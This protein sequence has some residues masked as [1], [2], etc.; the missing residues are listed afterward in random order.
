MRLPGI[1]SGASLQP[2]ERR[3]AI[4]ASHQ[5]WERCLAAVARSSI[6]P[7]L[8]VL[9]AYGIWILLNLP[10]SSHGVAFADVGDTFL[11]QGSASARIDAIPSIGQSIG[12]D[13]QFVYY[14]ALDATGARGYIDSPAYR[15]GR[16]VLSILAKAISLDQAAVIPYALIVLNWLAVGLGT[17]FVALWL[18]RNRVSQWLALVYGLYPGL[19]VAVKF[20][21]TEALAYC[22]VAAAVLVLDSGHRERIVWSALLFAWAVLSRETTALFALPFGFALLAEDL[23]SVWRGDMGWS[24]SAA[25]TALFLGITFG[26]YAAWKLCL[27]L[28]LG[29]F[30]FPA[31][32]RPTMMPFGGLLAWHPWDQ[33]EM[34][35]VR[36][37]AVPAMLCLAVAVF[38]VL[39]RGVTSVQVWILILN[40]VVLVVCL[41]AASYAWCAD[42]AR[43]AT[44]VPLAAIYALP[45]IDTATGRNRVWIYGS[46]MLWLWLFIPWLTVPIGQYLP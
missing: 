46:A 39:E 28:W 27:R 43:I 13:G 30:G 17:W 29:D 15:Y 21:L 22:F 44:G 32:L 14:I 1:N 24:K 20:D 12:Y 6:A 16:I 40:V 4:G 36:S 35:E 5:P 37:I 31:S 19:F 2:W 23:R 9:A 26:P 3:S 34:N 41:N 7:A 25:R 38:C 8:L 18:R 33:S 45:S 10:S 42:S 11:H